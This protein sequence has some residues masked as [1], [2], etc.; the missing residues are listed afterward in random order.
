MDKASATR[1]KPDVRGQVIRLR[2]REAL[3]LAGATALLPARGFSQ[4]AQ[5]P[6]PPEVPTIRMFGAVGDGVTNDDAAR[7]AGEAASASLFWPEGSYLVSQSPNLP[8]SWGPGKV[9]VGGSQVYLRPGPEPAQCIYVSV[10]SPPSGNGADASAAI[11]AA[12]D[13]AQANSL[14]VVF[15]PAGDF[16]LA[17]G[18]TFKHGRSA[19]DAQSYSVRIEGSGCILRPGPNQVA[20]TIA[21]RC[22]LQDQSTGRGVA[23]VDIRNLVIDGY[24]A[25]ATGSGLL[26]G[27]A[28]TWCD[29]FRWGRVENVEI[30]SFTSGTV[31]S[32]QDTRHIRWTRVVSRGGTVAFN[33]AVMGGFCGDFVFDT[34]EFTGTVACRPLTLS[35]SQPGA[36]GQAQLRGL[37]FRDCTFYGSGTLLS[38]ALYSQ[39]G[40]IWFEA[41][42]WDGPAGSPGE[43]ALQVVCTDN[44]Q[45]FQLHLS[46]A[47]VVSYTGA[48]IIIQQQGNG[49]INNSKM[50]GACFNSITPGGA[51]DFNSV[52]LLQ[53]T[54][55][56]EFVDTLFSQIS[57]QS[58]GSTALFLCDTVSNVLIEGSQATSCDGIG[59]GIKAGG[60]GTKNCFF[61]NNEM[62][63]TTPVYLY[64]SGLVNIVQN[65]NLAI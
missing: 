63:V 35:A 55:Q 38:A 50:V 2:R 37:H 52:V 29:N 27:Q 19:T 47:Y 57:G 14:S 40:D 46:E 54:S 31:I 43:S 23:D 13:F 41:C 17:N 1:S 36:S 53:G 8:I 58:G 48:P 44:A 61:L 30:Q 32:V 4:V 34:C 25:P 56:F 33:E 45:V 7:A 42:A 62:N 3:T 49:S 24:F 65:N 26:I 12:V 5:A 39:L 9:F 6:V 18:L 28:G 22:L 10:F 64:T 59:Y 16:Y 21:P 20:I 60:V 51:G 11:Q 15:P